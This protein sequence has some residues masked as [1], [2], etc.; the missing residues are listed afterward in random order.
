MKNKS[1]LSQKTPSY[2]YYEKILIDQFM[3][4]VENERDIE[5]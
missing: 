5:P 3:L 1:T 2:A 4:K